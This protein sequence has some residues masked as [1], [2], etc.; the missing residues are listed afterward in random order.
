MPFKCGF[1]IPIFKVPELDG[2]I[3]RRGR[4]PFAIR[5]RDYTLLLLNTHLNFTDD[6]A[7]VCPF[8]TNFAV[9]LGFFILASESHTPAPLL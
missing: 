4:Q 8:N 5:T 1:K 9:K 6:T 7:F 3:A 2:F